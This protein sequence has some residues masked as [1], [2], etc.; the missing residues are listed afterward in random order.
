MSAKNAPGEVNENPNFDSPN[1]T[2][3]EEEEQQAIDAEKEA[4]KKAETVDVDGVPIDE[5]DISFKASD[6][7]KKGKAEYFVNVEGAEQRKKEAEKKARIE[8]EEEE[9]AKKRAER[10]MKE[11]KAEE[12]AKQKAEDKRVVGELKQKAKERKKENRKN[13]R[14]DFIKKHKILLIIISII[15]VLA[16]IG[17]AV[18]AFISYKNDD[19]N[20]KI[21]E[22]DRKNQPIA[23]FMET[24]NGLEEK[25]YEQSNIE[26]A[27][28]I[29]DEYIKNAENDKYKSIVYISRARVLDNY[30]FSDPDNKD[31][32]KNQLISD[33][34]NGATLDPNNT[35][36]CLAYNYGERY[37]STTLIDKYKAL[38]DE[39]NAEKQNEQPGPDVPRV[40]AIGEDKDSG[41]AQK[42]KGEQYE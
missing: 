13:A 28:A 41:S 37:E 16:I 12:E 29:Y 18:L 24:I 42:D 4:R 35:N 31:L 2:T 7:S 5:K 6:I 3:A 33:V 25:F 34:D 8:A 26:N 9:K 23:D 20:K 17:V 22:L 30:M 36:V 19:N 27:I 15:V 39:A 1:I 40:P 11:I 32:I 21:E 14:I 38:C 10:V